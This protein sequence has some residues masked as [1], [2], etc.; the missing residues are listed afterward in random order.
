MLQVG[1]GRV[2]TTPALGLQ[3]A[4]TEPYPRAE[5]VKG[6]LYGR[7]L[8]AEDGSRRVAVVCLDL[9]ALTADEVAVLRDR[10]AA[11]GKLDAA[12]ILVSCSHTHAAPFTFLAGPAERP[13]V[14]GYLD[15]L[16]VR[17]E[18]AMASAVANLRPAE[19]V[20]GRTT[21]PGWAFN[22][23]PIYADDQVAT[24]GPTWGD[25]FVAMEDVADE[26]I[27]VLLARDPDGTVLGGLVGFACHPTVMEAQPVY[28][29]DFAGVLVGELEAR[30]GGVFGFLLGASGDT[31]NLDP[32]DREPSRWFG[33]THAVAMGRALAGRADDALATARPVDVRRIAFA[34]TRLRIP[35][36][37][38]TVE[39]VRLARWYLEEAPADLDEHEFTRR[40][41]GHGYT[42]YDVPPRANERHARQLLGMWEWQRRAGTREV[43]EEVEIQAVLLG[44]VAVLAYPVELFTAFGR[45]LKALSP[46]RDTFVATLANGWHGYAPTVD[47]FAHGGYEPHLAYQSRL[48]PAAGDLMTDAALARLH[49]LAR[50]G[51]SAHGG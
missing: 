14:L 21:A 11:K 15:T 1:V 2:D 41:T 50:R 42:F 43:V 5:G 12:A 45:R 34:V 24:H 29:S 16:S 30:L 28:S 8:V 40:F 32:A 26:E 3:L 49:H 20:V 18:E 27:Q 51:T 37:R 23:R 4:G 46:F 39:Q 9:M 33:W 44:D 22:R 31:A 48:I 35:Q 13:D 7:V 36:R 6:P 47:A 17:L 19:L 10:L 25:G 38:P